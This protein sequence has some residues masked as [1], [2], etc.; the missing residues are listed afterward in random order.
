MTHALAQ[1]VAWLN[2]GANAAGRVAL[3]PIAWMPGWLSITCISAVLGVV[4]LIAFK[5]TSPQRAIRRVRDEIQANMLAVKLFP[6]SFLVTLRCQGRVF[7][8][9]LQLL[10]LAI[11][12]MLVMIIPVSLVLGQMS[13]WY[14]TRPLKVGEE[15]IVTVTLNGK[16]GDCP[17]FRES[18]VQH[19]GTIETRENGTV[20]LAAAY[21]DVQIDPGSAAEVIAGPVCILSKREVCWNIRA[22]ESGY[23][24][25]R[26][27]TGEQHAAKELVI[28]DSFMRTSVERPGWHW[29]DILWHPAEQPFRADSPI[30]SIHIDYPPRD[31]WVSGTNGWLIYCFLASMVLGFCFRGWLKVDF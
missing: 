4:C 20:P 15:A 22:R 31:S 23:H 24:Q 5:Y 1:I 2:L 18:P 7:W 30:D 14:D 6:D 19:S 28:G 26:F 29:T 11:V 17:N 27:Q 9:A 25:L 16:A 8:G 12:P 13:L 3:A 21:P 10:W